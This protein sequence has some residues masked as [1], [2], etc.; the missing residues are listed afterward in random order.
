MNKWLPEQKE[1]SDGL[2]H[3][4]EETETL[5]KGVVLSEGGVAG[6]SVELGPG[7]RRLYVF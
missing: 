4:D 7:C 6:A 3:S 2:H 5:Q 1:T